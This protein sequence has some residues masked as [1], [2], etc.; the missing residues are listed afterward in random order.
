MHGVQGTLDELGTAL[1]RGHLRRRRPG[2]HGRQPRS[3]A[4]HRG[5]RGQGARRR[6]D[7]RVPDAG[8]PGRADPGVHL[9]PHR[10]HRPRWS[11]AR[12]AS[13]SVLPAFLEFARGAVLVAHN[14]PFDIGFLKAAARPHGPRLA[15]VPGGRHR[16]PGPAAGDPRRGAQP[17]A[18]HAGAA[19]RRGD[20][21]R[22]P[23][24]ARRAGD[25]RR[26]ARAARA[27]RQPRGATPWRSCA[28]FTSRVSSAQ[29]R[30]R[31]LAE[32]L[33]HAPGVYLFKD[34]QRPGAL[35]RHVQATSARRV[36]TYFT[37]SET[38]HPDGRDG[39][40]RRR[41]VTP[42]VCAHPARGRGPRAAADRR[43][44]A[45]LQPPVALPRA[46]AVAQAHRRGVPA[47]VASSARSATTAPPTSGRSAHRR[48]PSRRSRRCTRR[49]AAAVHPAA[50]RAR[51]VRRLRAGRDG[52]CGAPVHGRADASRTTPPWSPRRP[53]CSAATPARSSR[54]CRRGSRLLAGQERF[55][56]AGA[57]RDRLLRLV[58]GRRPGPAAGAARRVPRGGGRAAG[59]PPAAGR[60]CASGTAGSPDRRPRRRG[61]DP[62]PLHRRARAPPPRSVAPGAGP[63]AGGHAPRR[64]RA[65][66]AGSRRRAC[67]SSQLDGEWTCP[68]HGAGA[69]PADGSSRWPRAAARR[70]RLRR[71]RPRPPRVVGRLSRAGPP[72]ACRAI[73][74]ASR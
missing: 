69:A 63:A 60:S 37:A 57:V 44:Q 1:S 11:P 61:A 23:R 22:P 24:P 31:H 71:T 45:A 21:P 38:A 29:R 30:K 62:M 41:A 39:R 8:Q 12:R 47:A 49:A 9:R 26:A 28:T 15:P 68:V 7:R 48:R 13:S 35:R 18:V 2:D 46:G 14:A 10:H 16:P 25:G 73:P 19:V 6:G 36:R 17:Q 70:R 43:A 72:S 27:G 66:C 65:C 4:H 3:G 50:V 74:A 32:R 53:R 5:R 40:H 33:P 51:P 55:E 59:A 67:G 58:R 20:D 42:V 64:P 56:E 34:G 54:R 52:P